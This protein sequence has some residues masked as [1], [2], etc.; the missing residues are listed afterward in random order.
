[1]PSVVPHTK[2]VVAF[3]SQG[4]VCILWSMMHVGEGRESGRE[5]PYGC[6]F[7]SELEGKPGFGSLF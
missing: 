7:V 4:T 5:E 6:G 3:V 1:M 2:R